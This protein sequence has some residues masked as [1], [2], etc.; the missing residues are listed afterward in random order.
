L[1]P[2]HYDVYLPDLKIALEYQGEQHFRAIPYFGGEEGLLRTQ[3]RD[4]RK[5][6]ISVANG[7]YQI[8]VLPGYKI[9]SIVEEI[10]SKKP[11]GWYNLSELVEKAKTLNKNE[12]IEVEARGQVVS[13]INTKHN[14]KIDDDNRL[15][16]VIESLVK[17][18][19]K[20]KIGQRKLTTDMVL[21]YQGLCGKYRKN[22]EYQKELETRIMMYARGID[23]HSL[24]K[25]WREKQLIK[26][27]GIENFIFVIYVY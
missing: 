17:K 25:Y 15:I 14:A 9:A 4:R 24:D 7:V 19:R 6:E 21:R 10:A 2:Q 1:K 3:E 20:T 5:R 18:A 13:R 23:D 16:N 8:D 11:G 26:L 22:E 12:D 27:I